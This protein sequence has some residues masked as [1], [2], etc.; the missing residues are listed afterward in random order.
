MFQ[1]VAGLSRQRESCRDGAR[2]LVFA[3]VAVS[4]GLPETAA[5]LN[6]DIKVEQPTYA[7]MPVWLDVEVDE[8]C[9]EARYQGDPAG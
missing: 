3:F 8:P 7:G 4:V 5:A 6:I 1:A 9:A 2:A